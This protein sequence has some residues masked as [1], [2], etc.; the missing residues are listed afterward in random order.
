[1]EE[2]LVRLVRLH[3]AAAGTAG[4]SMLLH[5]LDGK[6]CCSLDGKYCLVSFNRYGQL[7]GM[8][9]PLAG[10]FGTAAVV[11]GQ[12]ALSSS[13]CFG[14]YSLNVVFCSVCIFR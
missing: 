11:V 12:L 13:V 14:L 7:S 4:Q 10:L 8:V 5:S 3:I 6:Y 2:L 1:M 9:E